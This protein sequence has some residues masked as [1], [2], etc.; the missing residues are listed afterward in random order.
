MIKASKIL[1]RDEYL[2]EI[3]ARIKSIQIGNYHCEKIILIRNDYGPVI[4]G[5]FYEIDRQL[6]ELQVGR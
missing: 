3:Y 5:T 2:Y 6:P 4:R 1:P